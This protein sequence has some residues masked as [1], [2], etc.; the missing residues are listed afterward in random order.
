MRN[1]SFRR[2]RADLQ[3]P[4]LPLPAA[5]R[6]S[7][8]ER[9]RLLESPSPGEFWRV[10]F[11][12]RTS[13]STCPAG[14]SLRYRAECASV[15]IRRVP[16]GVLVA[17]IAR[18]MPRDRKIWILFAIGLGYRLTILPEAVAAVHPR[19]CEVGKRRRFASGL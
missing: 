10:T 13:D 19:R 1:G 6:R 2:C 18:F 7:P 15:L 9:P 4:R 11:N 3:Q 14:L 17:A 5:L 16:P 8:E 12:D